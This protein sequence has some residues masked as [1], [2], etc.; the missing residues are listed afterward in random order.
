[1]IATNEFIIIKEMKKDT[2]LQIVPSL[3]SGGIERG[4]VEMNNYLVKNGF[5]SIVLSSGGKMVYQVEQGGGKHITLDVATKNPF[6]IWSNIDKIAKIIKDNK[7][8]VVDVKS[9]APAWSTYFACKKVRCPLITSM[10]GNYSLSKFPISFFKRKYNSSMVKGDFVVCVSNYVKDY[11]FKNYKI[12]R[13]KFANNR[14]KI[15]HRGVDIK[16]FNPNINAKERIV[17]LVNT[18]CIP[19]DKSIILLPGRL[20]EW[21]GQLYFLDVIAK[22]K[23]KN[24]LCLI[25][26]DSKGHE[27]Y[28]KRLQQKI[29]D[30]KLDEYVRLED[31]ISDMSALY[32]ISNI[33]VSSSIRGE[34]FGRI[35]PEAQA[36]ERMVVSTAIGG[37]LETIIDSET[38]WLVDPN[39]KDKFAEIIDNILDMPLDKREKIAKKA[40]QHI[41]DNFTV[42]K[43]CQE[44]ADLYKYIIKNKHKIIFNS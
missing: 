11:A 27:K 6:K 15:I 24:F 25:V 40:R 37:S 29:K 16:V 31:H 18:L 39:D 33:V 26:G 42:D 35:V 19:N 22:L 9:R 2:V 7:I 14:V 36:M 5:N 13:D 3:I 44:T 21:K 12:F 10:H 28:K 41:V 4:V 34:A 23:N 38:G 17:R 20:T 43:M 32:M 8:D 1:M 30:L